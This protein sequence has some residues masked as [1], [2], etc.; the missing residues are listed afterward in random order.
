[1]PETTA[2]NGHVNS[3]P[4]QEVAEAGIIAD[5]PQAQVGWDIAMQ[6]DKTVLV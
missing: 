6:R 1:V 3:S 2:N 4:G 5:L